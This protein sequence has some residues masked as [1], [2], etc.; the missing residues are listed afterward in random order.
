[1]KLI[2]HTQHQENYGAHDWDGEG[3]C[4]Q[5]WK[6]KGGDAI[7]V[8]DIDQGTAAAIA[9]AGNMGKLARD[10]IDALNLQDDEYFIE[11]VIDWELIDDS[12]IEVVWDH[13]NPG[14]HGGGD[15]VTRLMMTRDDLDYQGSIVQDMGGRRRHGYY[16][17]KVS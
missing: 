13:N 1:M 17:A 11:T 12:D 8:A 16:F 4:P 15:K 7:V 10:R 5:Y 3:E 2:V 6:N 14:R 9:A